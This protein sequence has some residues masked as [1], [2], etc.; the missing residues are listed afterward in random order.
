[1]CR[2]ETWCASGRG[3]HAQQVVERYSSSRPTMAQ[4]SSPTSSATWRNATSAMSTSVLRHLDPT[5]RSSAHIGSTSW[6]STSCS[7]KTASETSSSCLTTSFRSGRTITT[8]TGPS[9]PS[10][11]RCPTSG[12]WPEK[13]QP[14]CYRRPEN[15]HVELLELLEAYLRNRGFKGNGRRLYQ[16][17]R[18]SFWNQW[19]AYGSSLKGSTSANPAVS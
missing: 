2:A 12:S 4:S 9:A 18:R 10:T 3:W 7:T 16:S 17:R 1:M 15:L 11:D 8:T 13:P 5:V 6:S 19:C 14:G